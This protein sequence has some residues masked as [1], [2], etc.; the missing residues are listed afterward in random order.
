MASFIT[1][2]EKRAAGFIETVYHSLL[3][4]NSFYKTC[5]SFLVQAMLPEGCPFHQFKDLN[6]TYHLKSL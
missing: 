3:M 4:I 2:D 5:C 1:N 6:S